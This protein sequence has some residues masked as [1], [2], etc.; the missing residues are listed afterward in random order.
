VLDLLHYPKPPPMHA[1]GY[2]EESHAFVTER[3]TLIYEVH[4]LTALDHTAKTWSACATLVM[5]VRCLKLFAPFSKLAILADTLKVALPALGYFAVVFFTLFS[6]WCGAGVILFGHVVL[7]FKEFS[8]S[9][10]HLMHGLLLGDNEWDAMQSESGTVALVFFWSFL[11]LLYITL[12]NIMLAIVIDSYAE[13]KEAADEVER[14]R[15]AVYAPNGALVDFCREYA[16]IRLYW[17][18]FVGTCF[19]SFDEAA[20]FCRDPSAGCPGGITPTR[21]LWLL[22]VRESDKSKSKVEACRARVV[23]RGRIS[24]A[25]LQQCGI[26]EDTAIDM[27]ERAAA[28]LDSKVVAARSAMG[29]EPPPHVTSKEFAQLQASSDRS[30]LLMAERMKSMEQLQLQSMK[31][32]ASLTAALEALAP[33]RGVAA[34]ACAAPRAQLAAV[35]P[36]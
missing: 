36:L 18:W 31:Q 6:A 21:W 9:I 17:T 24:V 32:M 2:R 15:C 4:H 26:P 7:H 13:V 5:S 12:L 35:V 23:S 27:V 1:N 25:L 8:G 33:G 22:L 34:G 29:D 10:I 30:A 16:S 11:L 20:F 14:Q 3:E 28:V 19:S